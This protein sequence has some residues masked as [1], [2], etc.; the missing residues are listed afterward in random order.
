[1]LLCYANSG[2]YKKNNNQQY[3]QLSINDLGQQR[4]NGTADQSAA[5]GG[6]V[7]PHFEHIVS[8]V[9]TPL[10]PIVAVF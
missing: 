5:K 10:C 3:F 7:L 2:G 9:S 8:G 6:R 1:V 4:L